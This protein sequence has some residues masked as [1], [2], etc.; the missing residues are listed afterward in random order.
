[1]DLRT[2]DAFVKSF[3]IVNNKDL[4]WHDYFIDA[5]GNDDRNVLK[6]YNTKVLSSNGGSLLLGNP[7][8]EVLAV[9]VGDKAMVMLSRDSVSQQF[10]SLFG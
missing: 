7:N 3:F 9:A 2:Y 5:S 10:Q 1:M 6:A 4:S 8:E